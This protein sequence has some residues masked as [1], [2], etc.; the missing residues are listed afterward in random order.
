M[1]LGRHKLFS[2]FC[3]AAVVIASQL[4]LCGASHATPLAAYRE[5]VQKAGEQLD[6][7]SYLLEDE[8][9]TMQERAR[10]ET[11]T[12]RDVRQSLEPKE[13]VEWAGGALDVDNSWLHAELG[14]Y[15]KTAADKIDDRI[16]ILAR[17]SERL[18]ALEE[19]LVEASNTEMSKP[20]DKEAQK[21]RLHEILSRPEFAGEQATESAL[22][23]F[24]NR[25]KAWLN[26][27]MP[28]PQ[29]MP[30]GRARSLSLVARIFVYT[31]ALGVIVFI[32]WRYL[33]RVLNRERKKKKRVREARV[34]LGERL[35]ADET[36]DTLWAEADRLARAGEL[37]AAIRKAYIALL[38][39]LGERKVLHLAQHKTNQDYL[40]SLR[41]HTT[42]Y[43]EMRPLTANYERHWYGFANADDTD[44]TNF[45][46][47][48]RRALK[49]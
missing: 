41:E 49:E 36:P 46:A 21:G 13:R 26:R 4:F 45:R 27:L 23:R 6:E 19:R 48:C 12:L 5:R 32:L 44:W 39:E 34:V 10:Q 25:F 38:C 30:A 42:L 20:R 9:T 37:R 33:P 7:L 43:T 22:Q 16:E 24:W 40:R 28:T 3:A 2:L 1:N 18:H 31:L 14:A 11:V 47:L 8:E 17:T 29:P 15:E 35:A